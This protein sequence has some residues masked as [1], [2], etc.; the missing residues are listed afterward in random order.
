MSEIKN[1]LPRVCYEGTHKDLVPLSGQWLGNERMTSYE[2]QCEISFLELAVFRPLIDSIYK[3]FGIKDSCSKAIS[4]QCGFIVDVI[5]DKTTKFVFLVNE[6]LDELC[7]AEKEINAV[8]EPKFRLGTR[9]YT[10][11]VKIEAIVW[12]N[13]SILDQVSRLADILFEQSGYALQDRPK[14]GNHRR[15]KS[16]IVLVKQYVELLNQF[17]KINI[18]HNIR[19]A[20]SHEKKLILI[21]F[22]TSGSWNFGICPGENPGYL[23]EDFIQKL[24]TELYELTQYLEQFFIRML[25]DKVSAKKPN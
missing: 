3:V 6:V 8:G 5:N 12:C 15:M 25:N 2:G 13:S 14:F 17:E 18:S 21:P 11:V 16:E 7:K 24:T 4:H 9:Y 23:A 1:L 19:N 10:L 22:N 20:L